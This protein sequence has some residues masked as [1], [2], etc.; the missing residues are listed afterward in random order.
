MCLSTA[1]VAGRITH[2]SCAQRRFSRDVTRTCISSQIS[3]ADGI[4]AAG[5]IDYFIGYDSDTVLYLY[6]MTYFCRLSL[7]TM[8]GVL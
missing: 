3:T 7:T 6:F 2:R 5:N 1:L 8:S 4:A